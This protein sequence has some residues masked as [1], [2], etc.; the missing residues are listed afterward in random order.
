MVS[1]RNYFSI[2]LTILVIFFLFQ[3][4][5]VVRERWNQYDD[6]NS[7]NY[8]S[9][10]GSLKWKQNSSSTIPNADNASGFVVYIGDQDYDTFN[11]AR[12]WAEYNKKNF[13]AYE[14][15]EEYE[16]NGK[17]PDVLLIDGKII[18]DNDKALYLMDLVRKDRCDVIFMD[19]PEMKMLKSNSNLKDL[20]GINLIK[21]DNVQIEGI[22]FF[23]G[24]LFGG[25]KIYKA[26]T[27]ADEKKQDLDLNVPWLVT[28]DGTKTYAVGMMEENP[29]DESQNE[30]LPAII[31]RHSL[32]DQKVFGVNGDYLKNVYSG[33]GILD[34]MF[35]EMND[36]VLYPIINAQN[37]IL[38]GFPVLADENVEKMN[39]IYR[40]DQTQFEK[41]I[42]LSSIISL[43]TN[44]NFH[45]TS[46]LL[47]QY[48][49]T[50]DIEAKDEILEYYLKEFN[51]SD[52]EMGISLLHT[53]G[54]NN[55]VMDY[56]RD[57]LDDQDIDYSFNAIYGLS[58]EDFR[59]GHRLLSDIHT[60]V[61][62]CNS[63]DEIVDYINDD[64]TLQTITSDARKHSYMDNIKLMGIETALGYSNIEMNV[65]PSLWP[66][67][68]EDEWQKLS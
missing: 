47:P 13:F 52:S 49:Y 65:L 48:S 29:A 2:F 16:V 26:E 5:I 61:R 54:S 58:N 27:E 10:K 42:M 12:Q 34:A 50:D 9:L 19:L 38:P 32:G 59:K 17:V 8:S 23:D 56:I 62:E 20:L 63:D 28:L 45:M 21:G 4:T 66:Q 1:R 44:T 40:R 53:G 14:Q 18:N 46:F 64:V 37:L 67:N 41:D 35:Y 57:Y 51:E 33:I 31:W 55:Q 6:N 60:I 11:V 25:E 30:Y 43:V 24:F 15:I 3:G 39:E 7:V 22:H 68:E 36:Y